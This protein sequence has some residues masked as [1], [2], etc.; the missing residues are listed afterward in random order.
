MSALPALAGMGAGARRRARRRRAG[1]GATCSAAAV[2][3]GL[4]PLR[5]P[6]NWPPDT[7][8]AMLAATYAKQ[9]GRAVAFSLAAFRQAFAGGRDLGDEDTVLIAGGRM[10]DAPDGRAP[11]AGDPLGRAALRAQARKASVAGAACE[12]SQ[13]S[14][15]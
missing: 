14:A 15:R 9:I 4:Q 5:W 1:S 2:E 13:Q 11:G 3:L 6:A 12:A 10:R 8:I 7:A